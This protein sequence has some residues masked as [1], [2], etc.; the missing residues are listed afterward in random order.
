[1]WCC[2]KVVFVKKLYWSLSDQNFSQGLFFVFLY[3]FD[4]SQPESVIIKLLLVQ[5]RVSGVF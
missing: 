3:V 2:Y 5:K 1:M 4:E